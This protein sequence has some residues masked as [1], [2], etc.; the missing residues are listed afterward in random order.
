MLKAVWPR[1]VRGLASLP[2]PLSTEAARF[3]EIWAARTG[4]SGYQRPA[5]VGAYPT[6]DLIRWIA[7][8]YLPDDEEFVAQV[9]EAAIW[10]SLYVR[11]QDDV[12]DI[13]NAR[14]ETLLLANACIFKGLHGYQRLFSAE[15]PFWS[16]FGDCWVRFSATT[17]WEMLE[18]RGEMRPYTLEALQRLG[19]KFAPAA[20]PVAAIL[21]RA[22]RLDLFPAYAR[23]LEG[24]GVAIQMENDI[25]NWEEDLQRQ[26]YTFFLTRSGGNPA[27]AAVSGTAVEESLE[28]GSLALERSL[29]ALPDP[30]PQQL[31][32]Y[33]AALHQRLEERRRDLILTKLGLR[34]S[35]SGAV[36]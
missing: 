22:G 23:S 31:R 2:A 4:D 13:P 3:Q 12:L 17:A 8:L 35:A 11:L 36:E 27:E 9:L 18:H 14:R 15:H 10:G 20:I 26:N 5:A 16:A 28:A 30:A 32:A 34:S 33:L 19:E 7:A 24:L 25:A 1:V 21:A 6:P 29:A